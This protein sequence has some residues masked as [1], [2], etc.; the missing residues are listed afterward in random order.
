MASENVEEKQVSQEEGEKKAEVAPEV[1]KEAR[2]SGWVP[3]EEFRDAPEKWVDAETFVRRGNEINP[4]LRKHNAE[5]KRELQ[6]TRAE[7]QEAIQAARE[8]RAF[9][10]EQFERKKVELEVQIKNLR[11][12]KK[13]AITNGDGEKAGAI[14][15]AIDTLKDEKAALKAPVT[16]QISSIPQIDP[17]L[18]AWIEK[19]TWYGKSSEDSIERTEMTNALATAVRRK[20]QE[21]KGQ[22]FLDALD[23]EIDDKFPDWRGK[24]KDK[25]GSPV[26]GASGAARPSGGRGKS[27]SDLPPEAKAACDKYVKQKLLTREAYVEEYFS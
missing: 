18:T 23:R 17:S 21:L 15:E 24:K 16:P 6:A 5:L 4:I 20:N 14:E 1:L 12:A 26:E 27:Y 8:F 25:N 7:A 11:E 22:D 3:L 19:N 2:S 13:D 10:K 9:Q